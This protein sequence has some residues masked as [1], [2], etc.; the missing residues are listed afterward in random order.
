MAKPRVKLRTS[1][2]SLT[3]E[4]GR[5][6]ET[7]GSLI[8]LDVKPGPEAVAAAIKA[9]V[10]DLL[11]FRITSPRM[12]RTVLSLQATVQGDARKVAVVSTAMM[13]NGK[14]EPG[15]EG[16]SIFVVPERP[17]KAVVKII[18]IDNEG[19]PFR[20]TYNLELVER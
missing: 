4:T 15:S 11:Q 9:K 19:K 6:S 1:A 17:G 7:V 10:G 12:G 20:R 14:E 2:G 16:L 18:F 3:Q 8:R 5:S 13:A